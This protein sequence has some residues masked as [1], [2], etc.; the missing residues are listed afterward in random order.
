MLLKL[1]PSADIFTTDDNFIQFNV[2]LLLIIC[3]YPSTGSV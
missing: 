3:K 1:K 2:I